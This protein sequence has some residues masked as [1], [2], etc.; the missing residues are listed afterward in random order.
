MS[1]SEL[2]ARCISRN[3]TL[4]V[5]ESC[6]GGHVADLITN[7][8]GVSAVFTAGVIAYSRAAKINLLGVPAA[9]LENHGLISKET[10]V[11]MAGRMRFLAHADYAIATTGNLGPD[12][13]E[14]KKC[15]LVYV[16]VSSSKR[17]YFRELHLGG[18]RAANKHDAA[19]AALN[20]LAEVIDKE[21][22]D[23]R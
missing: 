18:N 13:L 4:A 22:S 9:I 6:T 21:T 16:A 1:I 19:L 12:V 2:I 15:G 3:A 10:A 11:T 14:G 20:L 17:V 7:I 23:D 5:A 8:P